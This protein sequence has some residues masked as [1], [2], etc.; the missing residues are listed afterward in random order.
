MISENESLRCS[1][2]NKEFDVEHIPCGIGVEGVFTM[3][4]CTDCADVLKALMGEW[5]YSAGWK[6]RRKDLCMTQ[7]GPRI[8]AEKRL[9]F[10]LSCGIVL[11]FLAFITACIRGGLI[12]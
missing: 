12:G 1:L 4:L 5:H 8:L 3:L 10:I 9:T 7:G 11:M 2:C 6:E